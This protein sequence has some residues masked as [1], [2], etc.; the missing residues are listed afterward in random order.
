MSDPLFGSSQYLMKSVILYG[1]VNGL[2]SITAGT[3]T[4]SDGSVVPVGSIS[5]SGTVVSL[6]D[7][8]KTSYS[9]RFTATKVSLL[10]SSVGLAEMRIY[11]AP[12]TTKG[13]IASLLSIAGL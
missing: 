6:G 4:F 8:G 12:A 2:N 5:S 11:N 13:L 1:P 7:D 3:L 10:T 9:V